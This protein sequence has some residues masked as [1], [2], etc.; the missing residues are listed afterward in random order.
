MSKPKIMNQTIDVESTTS[1]GEPAAA[2]TMAVERRADNRS[3]G[4]AMTVDELH[5]RLEFVRRVMRTE[6]KEGQ[7][8][9]KIPGAGEKP[10][11]LQPGAQKLLMTFN[12]REQVKKEVLREYPDMHREYEFTI[13]VFPA[14]MDPRDGWD[15]VGTCSTLESKYRY[16]KAERRC[17]KCKKTALIA[18]KPEY[19][20]GREP[21]FVCWKKKGGC[22]EI[23]HAQHPEIIS[24]P[25]EDIENPDPADCWNT[26]RK[27]GFKR[28]LV[29]AAINATNTSE[30]WTQDIEDMA[31][32]AAAHPKGGKPSKMPQD[33]PKAPPATVTP[34]KEERIT[35]PWQGASTSPKTAESPKPRYATEE[36]RKWLLVKL[37]DCL[38][39]ATE[40][41][42]KL[43]SPAVL[44]P[45][46][47]LADLPLSW[48]PVT[49]AQMDALRNAIAAFGNGEEAKHPYPQ[50][51]T[52]VPEKP[53]TQAPAKPAAKPAATKARDP[54]WFLD[55]IVP[56]P[57]KGVKRD[58]YLKTA[59]T[60]GSLYYR[61][62]EGDQEA[63]RRLFG[64][65]GHF[66]AKAWIG[67]DGQERPPSQTDIQFR[68]ALDAFNEWHEKH[69]KDT[70]PAAGAQAGGTASEEDELDRLFGDDEANIPNI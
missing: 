42:Q 68:E 57:P 18:E 2:Q 63:G 48:H 38:A 67:R 34:P 70:A 16:R 26:V 6:M 22:G 54:E 52:K 9:G 41:F 53:K 45:N 56:V 43:D 39:L 25:T 30:L 23:F 10:C 66:E 20:K 44:L 55:V 35:V 15:G 49:V 58:E 46:E 50:N 29:A 60:I 24:Q 27:M 37:K 47:T 33:A 13:T 17:P 32:N 61:T 5:E 14:G 7:D 28:G 11:L 40:Y 19:V 64:F 36:T 3:V 69:G 4:R 51:P 12:L 59:D 65:V 31:G 62:K 1:Q 21:G 8:Y